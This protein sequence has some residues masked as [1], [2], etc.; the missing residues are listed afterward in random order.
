MRTPKP[1]QGH[2]QKKQKTLQELQRCRYFS[3]GEGKIYADIMTSAVVIS[4]WYTDR[5]KKLFALPDESELQQKDAEELFDWLIEECH[6]NYHPVSGKIISPCQ[7]G[8]RN[9]KKLNAL[10]N[11]LESQFRLSVVPK[12]E[13]HVCSASQIASLKLSDVSGI[14][15]SG[16]HYNQLRAK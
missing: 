1:I 9:R 3:Y 4:S 12:G 13:N 2:A 15:T 11:I 7:P 16:Y 8:S 10:L 6:G 5:Y 14:F